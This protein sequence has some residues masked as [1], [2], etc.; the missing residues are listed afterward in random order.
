MNM[1]GGCDLVTAAPGTSSSSVWKTT[2]IANRTRG[3]ISLSRAV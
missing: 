3:S 1:T 2:A